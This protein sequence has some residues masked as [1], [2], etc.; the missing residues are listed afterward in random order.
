ML[1]YDLKMRIFVAQHQREEP[2]SR[3]QVSCREAKEKMISRNKWSVVS[4]ALYWSK[5]IRTE[6]V[7]TYFISR[8]R[9]Q[10][11]LNVARRSQIH[12]CL[13]YIGSEKVN[14]EIA[15]Y[16]VEKLAEMGR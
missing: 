1:K 15:I 3:K 9:P 12:K 8:R 11:Y 14:T 6:Q 4:N 10:F 16:T 5:K 2:R 7:N 13:G